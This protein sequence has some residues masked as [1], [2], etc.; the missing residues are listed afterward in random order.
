MGTENE[1]GDGRRCVEENV[2]KQENG[3]QR[4]RWIDEC[5][6]DL[7]TIEERDTGG[8]LKICPDGNILW[9]GLKPIKS[10]KPEEEECKKYQTDMTKFWKEQKNTSI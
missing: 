8:Q 5:V 10:C 7:R 2:E 4:R 1:Q 6:E 9:S 3:R